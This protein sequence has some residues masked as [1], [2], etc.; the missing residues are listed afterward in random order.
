MLFWSFV[1]KIMPSKIFITTQGLGTKDKY[2]RRLTCRFWKFLA[3]IYW[4][5]AYWRLAKV[6]IQSSFLKQV[7][8][9]KVFWVKLRNGLKSVL[10][11][12]SLRYFLKLKL[13]PF[14]FWWWWESSY[15][16]RAILRVHWQFER[17]I[18]SFYRSVKLKGISDKKVPN[19]FC[20]VQ[21][22]KMMETF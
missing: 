8:T 13:S 21:S 7:K 1:V 11:S 2:A 9:L 3:S 18:K 15:D 6:S 10:W 12:S 16:D 5:Q 20:P 19:P 17:Y 4:G 14:E 22:G